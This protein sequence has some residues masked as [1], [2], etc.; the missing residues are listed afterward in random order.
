MDRVNTNATFSSDDIF[1]R[2]KY[3]KTIMTLANKYTSEK[4]AC[5]IAVDAPWGIGKSTF[6]HMFKNEI[7]H[8]CSAALE[9]STQGH[10]DVF[11]HEHRHCVYYNAWEYDD[12]NNAFS[13]LFWSIV[14]SLNPNHAAEE[15]KRDWLKGICKYAGTLVGAGVA[16]ALNPCGSVIA[17][18]TATVIKTLPDIISKSEP[19]NPL[20]PLFEELQK[21]AEVRKAFHDALASVASESGNLF[22]LVDELDRCKPSFAIDTLE[23]IKHYFD[24]PNI[25]F[26]FA[27][28]MLQLSHAIGG[29]YGGRIDAGGYL[30]KFFDHHLRLNTP[31]AK[32][33][34][35]TIDQNYNVSGRFE[36][37]IE[38]VF[39]ACG[40][41]PREVYRINTNRKTLFASLDTSSW[42]SNEKA[43]VTIIIILFLCIKH[44]KPD[45]YAT[46]ISSKANWDLENWSSI[47]PEIHRFLSEIASC[48]DLLVDQAYQKFKMF[49]KQNTSPNSPSENGLIQMVGYF[50][51]AV[52]QTRSGNYPKTF[53]QILQEWL[54][55]VTV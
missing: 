43:Y 44:R 9:S 52:L 15:K 50:G 16:M 53:M 47:Y 39:L 46:F 51:S 1:E 45:I 29:R 40:I 49:Q 33:M 10:T 2:R 4:G 13:P 12:S 19:E 28:D 3:A 14:N 38:R 34:I 27:V 41:T 54:E 26:V 24:I 37:D 17:N 21:E 20:Q 48:G 22:I 32:Q 30:T 18:Q 36:E 31:T 7:D 11:S 6:L 23:V 8:C 35:H 5:S 42:G 25:V 55:A